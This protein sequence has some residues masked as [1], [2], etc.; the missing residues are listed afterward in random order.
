MITAIVLASGV[1]TRFGGNTPKQFIQYKDKD[2]YQH[3]LDCFNQ[4][5]EI[6]S[7]IITVTKPYL[8]IVQQECNS[9]SKPTMVVEGGET[10]QISVRSALLACPS[11]TSKVLIHDAAR[12]NITPQWV[13][14]LIHYLQLYPAICPVMASTD[15]LYEKDNS[16]KLVKILNREKIVR[17]QTP[18]GFDYKLI[19]Y[20]HDLAFKD[21][22]TDFTDD[23]SLLSSY[24]NTEIQCIEG[25]KENIK[26]TYQEDVG[27]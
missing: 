17:A 10:R 13:S 12:P 22:R 6:D 21:D 7:I 19:R 18:Q 25:L 26:I 8:Q 15:T 24:T 5:T 14:Y 16:G 2:L 23:S 11:G 20:A 1:G 27:S 9:Y 3:S 4:V